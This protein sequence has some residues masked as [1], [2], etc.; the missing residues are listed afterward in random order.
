MPSSDSPTAV[1]DDEVMP[2]SR[3]T[4]SQAA[5]R[6][7]VIRA[8]LSLGKT[9]GYEAVQMRAVA[10]EAGVALGTIYRYFSSKDHLLA[11]AQVLWVR[12][13]EQRVTKR[14][15]NRR[16]DERPGG[17]RPAARHVGDGERAE[18]VRRAGH[19]D[20]LTGPGAAACQ[21]DMSESMSSILGVALGDDF[22]PAFKAQVTNTLGYVWLAALIGWVNG[23]SGFDRVGDEVETA[24]HLVLDRF[25]G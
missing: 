25:D 15:P 12:E 10:A 11:A 23:W 6:D 5:R 22:D 18:A 8:A 21:R 14:P 4:A 13:L 24:T 17:E 20:L 16:H 1:T 3:L 2:P 7:R 19:G 9:G